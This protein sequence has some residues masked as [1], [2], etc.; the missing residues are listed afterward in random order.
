[1]D[2]HTLS[3]IQHVFVFYC[4]DLPVDVFYLL[5]LLLFSPPLDLLGGR[6]CRFLAGG[7]GP[8]VAAVGLLPAAELPV[9]Y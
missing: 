2:L 6:A 7:L 8:L 5:L 4:M 1:M 3:S 9:A